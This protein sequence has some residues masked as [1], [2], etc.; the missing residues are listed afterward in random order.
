MN[1]QN[2]RSKDSTVPPQKQMNSSFSPSFM[3]SRT[4]HM[5][6]QFAPYSFGTPSPG[7]MMPYSLQCDM[8]GQ[9][10]PIQQMHPQDD[11]EGEPPSKR[12]KVEDHGTD[13]D[14]D[15]LESFNMF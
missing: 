12:K 3:T 6:N 7:F 15:N 4:P 5:L 9:P 2:S 14:I 13:I 11:H 8:L 10:Q 1:R